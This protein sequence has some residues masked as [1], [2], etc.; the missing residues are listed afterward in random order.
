MS[1]RRILLQGTECTVVVNQTRRRFRAGLR[2]PASREP[3]GHPRPLIVATSPVDG[4]GRA[5]SACCWGSLMALASAKSHDNV[6][7]L[8]E[9]YHVASRKLALKSESTM[10][11]AEWVPACEPCR[12]IPTCCAVWLGRS[13]GT[14]ISARVPGPEHHFLMDPDGL[15]FDEMTASSLVKVDLDGNQLTP[16]EYKIN[17][18]F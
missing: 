3:S 18:R 6:Q 15:M 13:G 8:P 11:E 10:S 5:T 7:R 2:Y 4:I 12:R 1:T 16:S 17:P 9:T 14:H